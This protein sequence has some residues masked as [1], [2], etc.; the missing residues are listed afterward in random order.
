MK[1]RSHSQELDWLGIKIMN[2]ESR[3]SWSF[4]ILQ[5]V[6]SVQDV[7]VCSSF[8][9]SSGFHQTCWRSKKATAQTSNPK[10]GF[11]GVNRGRIWCVPE[12]FFFQSFLFIDFF[13][14]I[15][16]GEGCS[17][18]AANK[19]NLGCT[20]PNQT[21]QCLLLTPVLSNMST[22]QRSTSLSNDKQTDT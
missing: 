15:F 10:Y 21:W 19:N 2:L 13:F 8:F 20:D 5:I 14:S 1:V 18:V 16:F 7:A 17:S 3:H 12:G 11:M 6:Q 4:C 9:F 22:S